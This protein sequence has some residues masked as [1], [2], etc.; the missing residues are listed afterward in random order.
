MGI[1]SDTASAKGIALGGSTR[2]YVAGSAPPSSARGPDRIGRYVILE[3]LGRG[4]MGV[5]WTAYDPKLDR[6]VAIKRLRGSAWM[7]VR[8]ARFIREAQ[9]LARLN[10]AN[11]VTVHDVDTHEGRLYMAMECVDGQT[12]EDWLLTA[13][14]WPEIIEVFEQAGQGLAAAHAAGITHRDF[15]PSNMLITERGDVKVVDFGLAKYIDR[16]SMHGDADDR[17]ADDGQGPERDPVGRNPQ[18]RHADADPELMEMIDHSTGLKLTEIGRFVGTPAYMAPEQ[19][20]LIDEHEIG[21]WTDQF[22]FGATLYE[23]LYGRLP[24]AGNTLDQLYDNA[25]AERVREPPRDTL[26]PGWVHRVVLR[27]MRY[28]PD[29][30]FAS[31]AELLAALRADPARRRRRALAYAGGVALVGLASYGA[32]QAAVG[33]ADRPAPCRSSSER[34]VGVWDDDVRGAVRAGLLATDLPFAPDA[35]ARVIEGLDAYAEGWTRQHTA[36]CEA[37]RLHGEQSEALLDVRMTCLDRRRSELGALA[38][39]LSAAEGSTV[40]RAVSAVAQ[41]RPVDP[42]AVAQPSAE[43]I[44]PADPEERAAFLAIQAQL[45]G[46]NALLSAGRRTEARDEAV[47]IMFQT[48]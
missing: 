29:L 3:E 41:L 45:D 31:M 22:S 2:D 24:F 42:C 6:K 16:A 11:I 39:V 12:L 34:L 46:V 17:R 20:P 25:R 7:T 27:A 10:H 44:V 28:E 35:A 9:A 5:V 15:K 43:T 19:Y 18:E 47:V 4:G 40:T 13:R 1:L 30:R 32:L 26:V 14:R 33:D 21:A 23:A 48:T 8:Q 38:T 36:V 37:T